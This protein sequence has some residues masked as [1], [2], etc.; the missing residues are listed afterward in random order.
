MATVQIKW[1]RNLSIFLVSYYIRWA[2]LL[3]FTVCVIVIQM[4]LIYRRRK[5]EKEK[6]LQGN[7]KFYFILSYKIIQ[8]GKI[9]IIFKYN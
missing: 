7:T 4:S 6:M 1:P 9:E 3:G 8:R 2:R 5:K